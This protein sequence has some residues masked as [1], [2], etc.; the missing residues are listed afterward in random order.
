VKASIKKS[1]GNGKNMDMSGDKDKTP[2]TL[3]GRSGHRNLDSRKLNGEQEKATVAMLPAPDANC[4]RLP[5]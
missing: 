4:H 5:G 3:C 1:S 2:R